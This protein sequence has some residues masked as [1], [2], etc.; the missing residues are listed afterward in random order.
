MASKDMG[1]I[2]LRIVDTSFR[3]EVVLNKSHHPAEPNSKIPENGTEKRE[4]AQVQVA[5]DVVFLQVCSGHVPD[6]CAVP[7][8]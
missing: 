2:S 4:D 7:G 1:V 3:A 6:V 8:A 5:H